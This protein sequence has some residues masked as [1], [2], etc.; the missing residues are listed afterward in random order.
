MLRQRQYY[1]CGIYRSNQFLI[2]FSVEICILIYEE[3]EEGP[4]D[5]NILKELHQL[6]IITVTVAA[7]E[8]ARIAKDKQPL[9]SSDAE[10]HKP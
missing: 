3:E 10:N 9:C 1:D 6:P 4:N 8:L 7:H 5:S 2:L